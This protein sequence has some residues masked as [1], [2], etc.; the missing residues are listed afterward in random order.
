ME[1]IFQSLPSCFEKYNL[2]EQP[3]LQGRANEKDSGTGDAMH[4]QDLLNSPHQVIRS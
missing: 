4:F 1:S 3:W 2:L